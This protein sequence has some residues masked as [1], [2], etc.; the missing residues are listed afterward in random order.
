MKHDTNAGAQDSCCPPVWLWETR[1]H[2]AVELPVKSFNSDVP[3][4]Q[5]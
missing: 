3:N 1:I 2:A 5:K 4:A